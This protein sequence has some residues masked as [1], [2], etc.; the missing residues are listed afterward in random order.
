MILSAINKIKEPLFQ[1]VASIKKPRG[2]GRLVRDPKTITGETPVPPA[3]TPPLVF[4]KFFPHPPHLVHT[5]AL[6]PFLALLSAFIMLLPM[7]AFS[8]ET[9]RKW[10]EE[11]QPAVEESTPTP[12]PAS[13][14]VATPAAAPE[15][16]PKPPAIERYPLVRVNVTA[17]AFNF[18]Q[19]WRKN[20]PTI[21]EGLGVVLPD[22]HILV[23]AELVANHTYVELEQPETSLK[24]TAEVAI[25]DYDANLALLTAP[26]AE[27]LQGI[28]GAQLDESATIGDR[29]DILQLESNGKSVRTAATI[30]TI[31]V[32]P[33]PVD[34]NAF[35]VFRLSLPL[36]SRGNSFTLPAFRHGKLVGLLMR[37]DPRTQTADI[38][39]A[40]VISQFLQGAAK[41]PY[42]GFSRIGVTFSDT[43]DP[44]LRRF[45]KLPDGVGG[46]YVT[47]V[48]PDS[49]AHA[50]GLKHGD[51]LLSV[52]GHAIDQDG[53]YE[54]SRFGKISL[55]HYVS[56]VLHPGQ[57]VP[58][59]VW[60]DGAEVKLTA[61]VAPR[62]RSRM[63][64]QPYI[65]DEAPE[66]IIAG[67]LVF[68]ELSRQFLREWGPNWPREA[69]LKLVYLDR[70]QNELPTDR[71][72]IVFISSVLPGAETIGYEDLSG[73]IVE[74]V[75]GKPIRS[76]HDV[77]DA[78]N[79]PA[80]RFHRI[81]LTEDPGL[82][83]LDAEG[84]KAAEERIQQEYGL[85]ALRHLRNTNE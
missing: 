29:V 16:A 2:H 75:N 48:L 28:A 34:E 72:K 40:L 35:L 43:R 74:S 55:A 31:E 6:V 23:T 12:T 53:N 37:Y 3:Q 73:E 52:D 54:D 80:G 68:S 30:T 57:K 64:S 45:I 79:Q 36:Q 42:L 21:R 69:P 46:A 19:P 59:T 51:V 32:G 81:K 63:I 38:I 76:L 25:V 20:A 84:S 8:M 27:F 41:S 14:P 70:Y 5:H 17:Q 22:G 24:A 11:V 7:P 56:T 78:L 82:V 71:G 67:G 62:D 26:A 50:A 15:T 47:R 77:A 33:Y 58:L 83:I 60:R 9:L 1:K 66:Y 61:E 85:P 49:P 39:P 18:T 13:T 44:Q 65:F 4:A 10:T